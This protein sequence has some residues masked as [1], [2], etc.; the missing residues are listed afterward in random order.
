M[1]IYWQD[2][3]KRI[4]Q[5]SG[6]LLKNNSD[7]IALIKINLIIGRNNKPLHWTVDGKQVEPAKD[8]DGFLEMLGD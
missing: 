5:L 2:L 4:C 7:G 8:A 3:I 1:N 6:L